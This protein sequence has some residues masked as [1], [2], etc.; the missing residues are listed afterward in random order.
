M[1]R[2][3]FLACLCAG[4]ILTIGGSLTL[5]LSPHLSLSS[6]FPYPLPLFLS[7]CHLPLVISLSSSLSLVLS[8]SVHSSLPLFP[9]LLSSLSYL[10]LAVFPNLST[11][12]SFSLPWSSLNHSHHQYPAPSLSLTHAHTH[13]HTHTHTH[14]TFVSLC[15][16]R[17]IVYLM[18]YVCV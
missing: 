1:Y 3:R 10:S 16:S 2:Y 14:R 4:M 12:P 5:A 11:P 7:L 13:T 18:F 8:L 6:I 17:Y 15:F 9:F